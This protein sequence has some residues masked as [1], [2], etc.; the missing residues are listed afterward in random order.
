M[1]S[2][3]DRMPAK[4]IHRLLVSSGFRQLDTSKIGCFYVRRTGKFSMYVQT[5]YLTEQNGDTNKDW[6]SE[7]NGEHPQTFLK[8]LNV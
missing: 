3:K 5:H 2:R 6:I 1:N 8:R 4:E 7:I